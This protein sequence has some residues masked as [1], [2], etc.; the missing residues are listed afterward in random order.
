MRPDDFIINWRA[1]LPDQ[2]IDEF[3]SVLQ[4]YMDDSNIENRD[5]ILRIKSIMQL[6][7]IQ[8]KTQLAGTL[9]TL[10]AALYWKAVYDELG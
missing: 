4:A 2:H 6:S 3:T 1:T 9:Y 10:A 8:T 5:I 7:D